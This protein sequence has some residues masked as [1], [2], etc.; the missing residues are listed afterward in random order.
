MKQGTI[1]STEQEQQ[2]S[3]AQEN[4]QQVQGL[5]QQTQV[6]QSGE[7]EQESLPEEQTQEPEEEQD[8]DQDTEEDTDEEQGV[9]AW[10]KEIW[11][12]MLR[13]LVLVCITLAILLG[14]SF[15][16]LYQSV[17]EDDLPQYQVSWADQQL[18]A[19]G[20]DW[21]ISTT[22]KWIK[23]RF[24]KAESDEPQ[25]LE[26]VE[27]SHPQLM[28]PEYTDATLTICDE[29]GEMLFEGNQ[30]EYDAF[31]FSQNGIYQVTLKV[32]P[33]QHSGEIL[34][35]QGAY[36]YAFQ[37]ELKAKPTLTLSDERVPQGSAIG[38]KVTGALG[39]IA[40]TLTTDLADAIFTQYKGD[41]VAFLPVKYNQLAGEYEIS[42]TVNGQTV[43]QT[44]KVYGRHTKELETYT[45]NGTANVPYVGS[46]SKSVNYLWEINDPDVYWEESFIQ[47]VQGK[48][49]RDYAVL[50]YIDRLDASD[51]NLQLA[52]T[53]EMI[54]EYNASIRPRRSVNVTLSTRSGS[55]LV[56]PASGRIVY[57]GQ[58]SGAGK[59]IVIEH[60]CGL[61]SLFYT[62]A[63]VDVSEGDFV[64]QGQ[65]IGT[66][67][68]RV[69]CE[70]RLYDTPINPWEAW[71]GSGGLFFTFES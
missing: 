61:K 65:Q 34:Q 1:P 6:D 45:A 44:V 67:Q 15:A 35:A 5:N 53:P 63:R 71:R 46:L 55:A 18:Q 26:L 64:V 16:T 58:L 43:T 47:P 70:M 56:A 22:G 62:L 37:F 60:G 11:G 14:I 27:E 48:V 49:L 29:N 8:Q 12:P 50:E 66:V 36:T 31:A 9:L 28:L 59:T 30:V 33:S 23:H 41:W 69:I 7:E 24:H 10:I 32:E 52:L 21:S 25:Q 40:P 19:S 51:P 42:A 13:W 20:Y 68:S 2:T 38:V 4:E 39:E 54:A 3:V 57:A 17:S